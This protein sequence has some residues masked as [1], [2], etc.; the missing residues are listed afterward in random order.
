LKA[1]KTGFR[2]CF[3]PF[4]TIGRKES[5]RYPVGNGKSELRLGSFLQTSKSIDELGEAW[6]SGNRLFSANAIFLFR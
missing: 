4:P 6:Q 3:T 5:C 2:L 1:V